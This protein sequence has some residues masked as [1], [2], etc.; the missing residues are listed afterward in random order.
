MPPD[1][2]PRRVPANHRGRCKRTRPASH[3]SAWL[4]GLRPRTPAAGSRPS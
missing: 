1:P 2:P 4:P 3:R